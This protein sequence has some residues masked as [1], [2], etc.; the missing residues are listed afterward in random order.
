M[1]AKT[2]R[3]SILVLLLGS[4]SA[5]AK[6]HHCAADARA[7]AENLLKLHF[8]LGAGDPLSELATANT[9]N[10]F[11]DD[12]VRTLKP[13][14]ALVGK[15]LFDVVEVTGSIY[16]A[17]YRMRMIYAQIDETCLLMGQEV[18]EASDPY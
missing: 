3:A 9:L 15:G 2:F 7:R 16:K 17:D 1:R 6:Q 12:Q 4:V 5:F 10:I 8:V 18:I 14:R 13:I 11:I